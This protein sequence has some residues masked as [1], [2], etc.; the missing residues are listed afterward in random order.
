M[1]PESKKLALFVFIDAF[2]WELLQRHSFLDDLLRTK[3][4][5]GTVLGYSSACDPT[6]LTGK[7]P[8][9]H[10]HFSC[11]YFAPQASPFGLCRLLGALPRSLARRARV[12]RLLSGAIQRW[13][14]YTGY[15]QLYNVPFRYLPL[16]D[17]A[18]KR[19]IYQPGGID[20]GVPTIFDHLRERGIPFHLSDWRRREADNLRSLEEA[21]GRGQVEFAY[22][23]LAEMDAVLHAHG[24][25][26]PRAAEKI[27]WYSTRIRH[28]VERARRQYGAVHLHV[29]SDHGMA[30]VTG[31]CDLM[32][33]IDALGLRFGIDYAAIYDSTMA[34]FWFLAEA[35]RERIAGALEA[36]PRGQILSRDQLSACGCDFAEDKYGE[37]FF[38]MDPGV[39]ICP[40]FMGETRLAGMHGYDPE[41]RDSLA[42]F[43]SN[44]VP[45][46]LPKRLDDLYGLMLSEVSS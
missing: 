40:S 11:F 30:E 28:L 10:G 27:R 43:A 18:E 5:L 22:L 4:P 38:L 46:P 42:M 39:L 19:D 7:L 23:Y 1:R 24:T 2:G 25:R 20:G 45:D 14:G 31:S 44:V 15:F 41:C 3:V 26:S 29:F 21:I 32:G 16:F 37:L 9:E 13:H 36:E 8:R 34:R 33:R 12:R 17:Y 6:I 35:A